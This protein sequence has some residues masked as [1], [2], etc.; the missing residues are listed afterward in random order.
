MPKLDELVNQLKSEKQEGLAN[1]KLDDVK[2]EQPK[3]EQ[4]IVQD[5]QLTMNIKH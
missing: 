4:V 2:I 3:N 5:N 1:R